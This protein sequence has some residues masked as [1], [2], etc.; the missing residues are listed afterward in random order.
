MATPTN[1]WKLGLFVV[2]GLLVAFLAVVYF[3]TGR[4]R[5]QTLDYQTY[6]DESVQGL[7]VGAPVRFRGVT[8]GSVSEIRIAP[9]R[10]LVEVTCGL[11]VREL[12]NSRLAPAEGHSVHFVVPPD[13]RAQLVVTGLTGVEVLS[14]DFV[15]PGKSPPIALSFPPPEHYIPSTTS[16]LKRIEDAVEAAADHLPELVDATTHLI[17]ETAVLVAQ[18]SGMRLG[19]HANTTFRHL[20]ALL[21]STQKTVEKLNAADVGGRAAETLVAL[22]AGFEHLDQ[23]LGTIGGDKGLVTS[24]QRATDAVGDIARTAHGVGPEL[25]DTLREVRDTAASIKRFVDALER[26]PDMLVKGRAKKSTP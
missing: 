18:L 23:L 22:N 17:G 20:D 5:E 12:K 10:R 24:A 19:D 11:S 15:D 8:V 1:Y 2:V 21:G 9:D 25:E 14:L 26:E 6:F 3:G 16:T 4:V 7:E 13:L